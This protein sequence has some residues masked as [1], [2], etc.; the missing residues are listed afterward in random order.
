MEFSSRDR[1]GTTVRESLVNISRNSDVS[2]NSLRRNSKP[3]KVQN[4]LVDD[5]FLSSLILS[6]KDSNESLKPRRSSGAQF[7]LRKSSNS[8]IRGLS[9]GDG[10]STD[11][12]Y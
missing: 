6:S 7:F 4:D 1:I 8:T 11:V 9:I 3:F 12:Q 10:D 5:N 2:N